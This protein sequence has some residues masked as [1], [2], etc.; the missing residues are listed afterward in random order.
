[1]SH[2]QAGAAGSNARSPSSF[3]AVRNWIG[4]EGIAAGLLA[5][6]FRQG[7][8]RPPASTA[9][10]LRRVGRYR[11]AR[12]GSAQS[13]RP[14]LRRHGSRRESAEA[15]CA[16]PTSLSLYA[17]INNRW[18]T[19][20]WVT[21]LLEEGRAWRRPAIAIVEEQN[22][23]LLLAREHAKEAP[24]NHLKAVRSLLRRQVRDRRLC[25]RQ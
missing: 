15:E 19:S 21:R 14:L 12:A 2:R 9:K 18:R 3:S 11:R 23:G 16:G 5:H 13:P 4:K 1:M 22:S 10:R 17:P 24:E 6:Q 7:S 8:A 25:F 20:G